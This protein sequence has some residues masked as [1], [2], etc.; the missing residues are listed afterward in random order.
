[1]ARE[2]AERAGKFDVPQNNHNVCALL[3]AVALRQNDG[4]V[5]TK[6]FEKAIRQADELIA[7]NRLNYKALDTRAVAAFGLAMCGRNEALRDAK[8]CFRTARRINSDAGVVRQIRDL[9]RAFTANA[10]DGR[11]ELVEVASLATAGG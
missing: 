1:M 7:F 5:A 3:G 2:N 11:A 10:G 8:E 9:L 4:A 6:A